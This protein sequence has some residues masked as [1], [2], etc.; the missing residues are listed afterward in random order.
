MFDSLR[1]FIADLADLGGR[2][3]D[4]R[5]V[6]ERLATAALLVHTMA[7]DGEITEVEHETLER[8]LLRSFGLTRAETADL[9][10]AA[11][12]RDQEAVDLYGFTSVLKRVLDEAGRERVI[13]AMW[14][15]VYADGA[16]HELEDN[17]VWRVA[18]LLGVSG[19]NRMLLKHRI[20]TRL[21]RA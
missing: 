20:E 17:M 6:D 5:P 2:D 11:R 1:N 15:L 8:V 3:T 18:D 12:Q 10:E 4:E 19:R 7:V 16:V 13:E 14:E 9:I 21:A